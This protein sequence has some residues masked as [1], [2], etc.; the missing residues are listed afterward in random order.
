MIITKQIIIKNIIFVIAYGDDNMNNNNNSKYIK[1]ISVIILCQLY[2]QKA[3]HFI[4]SL[5]PSSCPS[6]LLLRADSSPFA[7][8]PLP[9]DRR[10]R[11]FP[12]LQSAGKADADTARLLLAVLYTF[13]R[14]L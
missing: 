13:R 9:A 11:S 6:L 5:L 10:E 2:L 7:W 12:C 4:S 1:F 8:F 3:K 14:R